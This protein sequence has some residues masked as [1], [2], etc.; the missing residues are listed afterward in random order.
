M[1]YLAQIPPSAPGRGE[2]EVSVP[3]QPPPGAPAAPPGS[4]GAAGGGMNITMMLLM[5][6]P[7]LLIIF[8]LNRSQSKKQKELESKLKKGDRVVTSSGLIGKITEMGTRYVKLEISPGVKIQML[9]TAVQ[10]LDSG[11][12]PAAPAAKDS[13]DKKTEASDK[14][15]AGETKK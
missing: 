9:K 4:G 8:L 5:F 15:A 11:E 10:G 14:D 13:K 2:G 3:A 12:E 7:M 6:A 1:A